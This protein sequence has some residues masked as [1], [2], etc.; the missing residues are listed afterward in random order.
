[1]RTPA[2]AT[3]PAVRSGQAAA[4][5]AAL[6]GIARR[7]AATALEM[8]HDAAAS[9]TL[10][11]DQDWLTE[12]DG[13]VEAQVRDE[14]AAAFPGDPVLGEEGGLT[15]D[16]SGPIWIVDP[17][18]GTSN[19]AR[20]GR[21]WCV[22]IALVEDGQALAGAVVAP[23]LREAWL[24]RRGRGATLN[25]RPLAAATTADL[26]HALVELGWSPRRPYA[27]WQTLAT[28]LNDAGTALRLGGSGALGLCHVAAGRTD[29][30]AEL[31]INSWDAAAALLIAEEAG[32]RA[33]DILRGDAVL[34]GA[35]VLA[36][37][38]MLAETLAAVTGIP[39]S[40]SQ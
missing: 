14:I 13:A 8:Q 28:A 7:A 18:D 37:A 24:G 21:H 26:R 35:P 36:A 1:M 15:G 3:S 2:R 16:A 23:A 31:H 32:A 25:G 29:A 19:Y 17:I 40:L 9:R 22:S 34:R 27:E 11:G 4:R 6:P 33:S 10:K 20:G 30:Y 39:L 5:I 12:A 38:P